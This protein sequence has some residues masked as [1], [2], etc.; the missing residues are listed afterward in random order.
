MVL[1]LIVLAGLAAQRVSHR[2]SSVFVGSAGL[3][4]GWPWV[5]VL[6]LLQQGYRKRRSGLWPL[7]TSIVVSVGLSLVY[8]WTGLVAFERNLLD[9]RSQHLISDSVWDIPKVLFARTGLA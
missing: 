9:A 6:Y 2:P 7:V 3:V 4:K 1:V 8:G 5:C